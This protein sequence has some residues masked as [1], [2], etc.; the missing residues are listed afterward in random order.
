MGKPKKRRRRWLQFSLRSFLIAVAV[1]GV[2]FGFL[3]RSARKQQ[4]A[5]EAILRDGGVVFY[6]FQSARPPASRYDAEAKSTVPAWLLT[7]LGVDL[8]HDVEAIIIFDASKITDEALPHIA[9]LTRLRRL[10]LAGAMNITDAGVAHLASLQRLEVFDVE[11]VKV[12]NECLR[13]VASLPLI[14]FICMDETR[15]SDEGL[16]HLK[17]LRQLKSLSF[18]GND[19]TDA[20]LEQLAG[21]SSLEHLSLCGTKV[22]SDGLDHLTGLKNLQTLFL[23]YPNVDD[24]TTLEKALPNCAILLNPPPP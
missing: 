15:V 24:T 14:E 17:R 1:F 5:V 21:L 23:T 12:G 19:I 13:I 9:R 3:V 20:G 8:F 7:R 11:R 2:W 4:A 22:T 10:H 18:N 16:S 6:D